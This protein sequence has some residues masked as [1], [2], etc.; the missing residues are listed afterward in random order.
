MTQTQGN[1]QGELY[2]AD[3]WYTG[4]AGRL[5]WAADYEWV[6]KEEAE[7]RRNPWE[8]EGEEY[9]KWVDSYK[10]NGMEWNGEDWAPSPNLCWNGKSYIEIKDGA[11]TTPSWEVSDNENKQ[12][13]S[14]AW[15]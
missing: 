8:Y 2:H 3:Y 9:E 4:C 10:R 14:P 12:P 5:G 11:N 7:R 13:A 1:E 6:K 15:T